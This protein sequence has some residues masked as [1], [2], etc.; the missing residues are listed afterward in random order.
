MGGGAL[1]EADLTSRLLQLT[2]LELPG[3]LALKHADRFNYAYPDVTVT[4]SRVT[5]WMEVKFYNEGPFERRVDQDI[6]CKRLAV[7]GDC[8]YIIFELRK[9]V[10]R[11]LWVEPAHIDDWVDAPD[12]CRGFDHFWLIQHMRLLHTIRA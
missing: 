7:Q 9:G 1:T 5:S 11:T 12:F 3:C 6:M 10:R 2:R 4:W 8:H